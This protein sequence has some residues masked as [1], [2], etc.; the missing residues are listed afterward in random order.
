MRKGFVGALLFASILPG[1]VQDQPSPTAFQALRSSAATPQQVTPPPADCENLASAPGQGK[2]Y[3]LFKNLAASSRGCVAPSP[4]TYQ[5]IDQKSDG[6]SVASQQSMPSQ[7]EEIDRA[8][9]RS[10]GEAAAKA[11]HGLRPGEYDIFKNTAAVQSG[12]VERVEQSCM[13]Q[14]GYTSGASAGKGLFN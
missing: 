9:C 7:Q 1:C 13:T 12:D 3:D 10:E 2:E 14:R 4:L 11:A 8:A 6:H 5:K